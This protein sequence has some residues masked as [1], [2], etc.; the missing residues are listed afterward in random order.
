MNNKGFMMAEVV[1]V[2][3]IIIVALVAFYTSYNKIISLYNQRLDY[4]D[5]RTLYE[6]ASVREK[7]NVDGK[8]KDEYSGKKITNGVDSG[9]I[10]YIVSK[11]KIND[12]KSKGIKQTFKDYIDYLS[13]S[14]GTNFDTDK[15]LVMERCISN[16]D[17]K[18]AYLEV[19]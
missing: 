16:D 18:Y 14:K 7:N 1:V 4:Y 15:I 5:V 8:L 6:L 3:S 19:Y 11:N 10:V 12:L 17:C 13:S 2:S 9:R